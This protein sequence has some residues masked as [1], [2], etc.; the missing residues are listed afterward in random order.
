M[1][2][3][4]IIMIMMIIIDT[5]RFW[6]GLNSGPYLRALPQGLTSLCRVYNLDALCFCLLWSRFKGPDDES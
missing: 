1:G 5:T 3:V 6:P 4:T 2:I